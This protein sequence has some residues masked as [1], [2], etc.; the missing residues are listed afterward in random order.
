VP[1][2][3]GEAVKKIDLI[4][5]QS[6]LADRHILEQVG[7]LFYLAALPDAVPS[8][9]N[10]SNYLEILRDK[11]LLREVLKT[12]LSAVAEVHS[13]EEGEKTEPSSSS[14][15]WRKRF[16]GCRRSAGRRWKSG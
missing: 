3:G 7:G 1:G 13:I 4:T 16:Y 9:A 15:G 10:L 5:L 2:D 12:S 8:A 14:G 11:W 6:H